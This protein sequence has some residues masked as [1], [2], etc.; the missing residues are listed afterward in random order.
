MNIGRIFFFADITEPHSQDAVHEDIRIC[1]IWDKKK[2][3][4]AD[5]CQRRLMGCNDPL[6]RFIN[7]HIKSCTVSNELWMFWQKFL[8]DFLLQRSDWDAMAAQKCE[9]K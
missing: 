2:L 7:T 8:H 9:F 4:Y 3:G 5:I 1:D 6:T